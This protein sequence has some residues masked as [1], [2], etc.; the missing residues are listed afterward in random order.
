[1]ENAFKHGINIQGSSFVYISFA[2]VDERLVFSMKN[3]NPGRQRENEHKGIGIANSRKRLDLLY[4]DHYS[5][6]IDEGEDEYVL[7]LSLPL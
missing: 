5:L 2:F 6:E 1:V 4:G 3:S 7:S